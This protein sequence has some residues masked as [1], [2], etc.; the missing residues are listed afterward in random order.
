MYTHKH[1]Y[2]YTYAHKCAHVHTY[3]YLNTHMY[4]YTYI[5]IYP[6]GMDDV[7][8]VCCEERRGALFPSPMSLSPS[9]S[10]FRLHS[11]NL[12]SNRKERAGSPSV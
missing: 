9:Y 12:T 2:M 7:R 5:C 11:L 3:T 4:T 6:S 8:E 10:G 1:I